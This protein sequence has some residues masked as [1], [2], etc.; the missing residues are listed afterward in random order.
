MYSFN[1]Y[2][3]ITAKKKTTTK[4]TNKS[5]KCSNFFI[6][7]NKNRQVFIDVFFARRGC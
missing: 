6:I 3:Q 1:L 7:I 2:I 4:K 5:S